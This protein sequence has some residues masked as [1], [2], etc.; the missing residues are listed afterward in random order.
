MTLARTLPRILWSCA[1]LVILAGCGETLLEPHY[2]E[3]LQAYV[4]QDRIG[5]LVQTIEFSRARPVTGDTL[6][7]ESVV[8]NRGEARDVEARICGLDL[9]TDLELSD[10]FARCGG[11]STSGQLASG[12]SLRSSEAGVIESAAGVYRVRIRHLLD[13]ER[14]VAV[15]IEVDRP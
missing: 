4:V 2:D 14:W 11:Y 3:E 15:E 8:V 5:D 6:R 12:D 1:A 13:P 10:P 9:D 7:I